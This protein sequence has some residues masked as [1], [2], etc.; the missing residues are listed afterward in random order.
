MTDYIYDIES[1]PNI[2]T[3]CIHHPDND[4]ERWLLEISDRRNDFELFQAWMQWA[5]LNNHRMVGFNNI[6]YDYPVIHHMLS[7]PLEATAAFAY[8][9]THAIIVDTSWDD[10][11]RHNVWESEHLV[12]QVDLSTIRHFDNQARRTSLKSLEYTMRLSSIQ[13]LPYTPGT[14]LTSEQMDNLIKYNHHDVVAT[15]KFYHETKPMIDF[16]DELSKKYDMNMTNFNDTKIGKSYFIQRLEESAPG[17]CFD[18]STG[19][20]V[21][22][23]THRPGG[24]KLADVIFPYVKF[25]QP[26]FNRVLDYM[27]A[28][29]ITNTKKSPELKD[30]TAT[31]EGFDYDF[32]SGGIHGSIESAIVRST[33]THVVIDLDVASYYPNLAIKNRLYPEHLGDN[34]CHIYEDLY[35][36]RKQ[37]KKGTRENAM[38]K[39]ALNGTYGESNSEYGPFF[40]PQFTMAITINGQLLLC[41]LAEQLIKIPDL[42][43]IQI[44]TDGLTVRV[45]RECEHSVVHIARWWEAVTLLELESVEYKAMYIRDVNNYIAEKNDGTLK[46]KGKYCYKLD[47]GNEMDWHQNLSA[48]VV[49]MA[50]EAA[51]VRGESIEHFIRNHDEAFDFMLRAKVNSTSRLMLGERQIQKVSRYYIATH[52]EML[53]KVM[54]PHHTNP[55][56]ERPMAINKGYLVRECNDIRSA[57][58][59]LVNFDWYIKEAH[60]IVDPLLGS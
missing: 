43:M 30:L 29:T 19:K 45:P 14:N 44:N 27:R 1:Y 17:C 56:K 35:N 60:K 3:C 59:W 16:R 20:K 32:G 34:F 5:L 55:E 40:D 33:D 4:L 15:K 39:L 2:F 11:F 54:P 48:L 8:A 37:H 42:E 24:I 26:E 52:G 25:E 38:L 7:Y 41:M 23:Q 31:V 13:D 57:N 9:K 12:Q 10:R 22:R 58:P 28:T 21:K 53:T 46:R 47:P 51:L 50:A 18:R 36:M 6:G 49:P